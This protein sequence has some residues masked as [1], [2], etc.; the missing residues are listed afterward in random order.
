MQST[1]RSWCFGLVFGQI[2]CFLSSNFIS[3]LPTVN[4]SVLP[5]L[6]QHLTIWPEVCPALARS[7]A[8]LPVPAGQRMLAIS[9]RPFNVIPG[10]PGSKSHIYMKVQK[11]NVALQHVSQW[12]NYYPWYHIILI[13]SCKELCRAILS[14]SKLQDAVGCQAPSSTTNPAKSS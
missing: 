2:S 12:A 1:D 4:C 6:F 11:A 10:M 3:T 8:F 13:Y 14:G 5:L 7:N 9:G